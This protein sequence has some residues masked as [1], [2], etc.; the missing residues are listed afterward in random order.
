MVSL[1]F[2][3]VQGM[4]GKGECPKSKEH[5]IDASIFQKNTQDHI[6]RGLKRELQVSQKNKKRGV[7]EKMGVA[8]GG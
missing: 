6:A 3:S 2:S 5:F 7:K 1:S 4:E 8:L